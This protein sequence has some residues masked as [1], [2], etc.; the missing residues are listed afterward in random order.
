MSASS[1]MLASVEDVQR[2]ALAD[3][4]ARAEVATRAL[5]K[6]WHIVS[7][8]SRAS[9]RAL[10]QHGVFNPEMPSWAANTNMVSRE[11]AA[12]AHAWNRHAK[13]LAAA[14][15]LLSNGNRDNTVDHNA[16]PENFASVPE[17]SPSGSG[18]GRIRLSNERG[19]AAPRSPQESG[20]LS[21][22]Y[23]LQKDHLRRMA[24]CDRKAND[25]GGAAWTQDAK[26]EN[27]SS[28]PIVMDPKS[29]NLSL[30]EL[31]DDGVNYDN[32]KDRSKLSG[33]KYYFGPKDTR[34]APIEPEISNLD[35]QRHHQVFWQA[36]PQFILK[37]LTT[38]Q[39][40]TSAAYPPLIF[41]SLSYFSFS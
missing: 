27:S 32:Y 1:A 24:E 23:S 36:C 11:L 13:R 38:Q 25:H 30:R 15:R 18:L 4:Q 12:E 16:Y 2:A 14:L 7:A 31:A 40:P 20:L 34:M 3:A 19:T 39:F 37:N 29:P 41:L 5:A 26:I 9:H 35:L 33:R 22:D 21:D 8:S 6:Q 10:Q 17:V 28:R